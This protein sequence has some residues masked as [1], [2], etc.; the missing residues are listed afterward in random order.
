MPYT[1]LDGVGTMLDALSTSSDRAATFAPQA[2]LPL[3]EAR[4]V[5]VFLN[6]Q[7]GEPPDPT[8]AVHWQFVV[9]PDRAGV[10]IPVR[11]SDVRHGHVALPERHRIGVRTVGGICEGLYLELVSGMSV[12]VMN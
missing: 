9:R 7:L 6:G 5:R 3:R 1:T 2:L 12:E 8:T 4:T 10:T 11:M